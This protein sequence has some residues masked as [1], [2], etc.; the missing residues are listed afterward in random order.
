MAQIKAKY[1]E[2]IYSTFHTGKNF[3]GILLV[4]V[5]TKLLRVVLHL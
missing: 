2:E 4:Y 1:L 5:P 3:G